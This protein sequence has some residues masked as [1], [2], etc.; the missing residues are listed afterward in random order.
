MLI[1]FYFS[2]VTYWATDTEEIIEAAYKECAQFGLGA[3]DA[4]HISAVVSV[5]AVEFLTHEKPEKSIYR[6]KSIQVI[7]MRP[8][9]N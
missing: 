1:I 4:L 7:S 6:T 5:G 8:A 2:L 3:M 9:S